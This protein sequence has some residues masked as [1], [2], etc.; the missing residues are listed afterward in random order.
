MK[1]VPLV[2]VICI[3][4]NYWWSRCHKSFSHL[5]LSGGWCGEA[6]GACGW[7]CKRETNISQEFRLQKLK[8][9][10]VLEIM[11]RQLNA[12]TLWW[13]GSDAHYRM[14]IHCTVHSQKSVYQ[15]C[16]VYTSNRVSCGSWT[17]QTVMYASPDILL[18]RVVFEPCV[19]YYT[20]SDKLLVYTF[21]PGYPFIHLDFWVQCI[22]FA[23]FTTNLQLP[24]MSK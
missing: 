19:W 1:P 18:Q 2:K 21:A 23:Q 24:N 12:V 13:S 14:P 16:E 7:G 4:M 10:W 3:Q 15:I 11:K 8:L 9:L 22:F 6:Q 5:N 17:I 20:S